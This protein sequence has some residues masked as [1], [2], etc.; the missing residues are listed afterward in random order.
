MIEKRTIV[1]LLRE[2]GFTV[3]LP[4]QVV[5]E[6]AEACA[7]AE[8]PAGT[9]IF[10][11]GTKNPFV[12]VVERGHVGLDMHVPGRGRVR[13]LSVGP[14]EMLAWSAL[15]GDGV[16]TVSAVALE[17]T[18]A[19]A[20]SGPKLLQVCSANHEVGYQ[21]M[22]RMAKALA[23]RLVATRL[24]LLDLFAEPAGAGPFRS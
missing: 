8:F 23:Q 20:A 24:Q 5:D 14:G 22:C 7:V 17:D 4:E 2:L 10:Q 13:V 16:M 6:L 11:E 15:L 12:Y 9:T 18:Q 1:N 19:L 21:L 3:E